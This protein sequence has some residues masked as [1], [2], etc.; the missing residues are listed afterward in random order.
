MQCPECGSENL[1]DNRRENDERIARGEKPR[2]DWK[3]KACDH[4][5]WRPKAQAGRKP[6]AQQKQGFSVGGPLPGEEPDER[7]AAVVDVLSRMDKTL[8]DE[9][10]ARSLGR[11][12]KMHRVIAQEWLK[13]ELPLYQAGTNPLGATPELAQKSIDTIFIAATREGLHK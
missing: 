13:D 8:T 3:C 11:L 7:T 5:I 1:Y 4:V 12:V 6:A 10:K 9:E 2:P